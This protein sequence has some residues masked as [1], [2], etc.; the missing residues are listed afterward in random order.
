[1]FRLGFPTLLLLAPGALHSQVAASPVIVQLSAPVGETTHQEIDATIERAMKQF[2]VPG[3]SVAVVKEGK[4]ILSKGYGVRNIAT[5]QPMTSDTIVPIFS[6][7]KQFTSFAAGLMVDEKKLAFNTPVVSYFPQ[8]KTSDPIS[9]A[10]VTLRDLLSHRSGIPELT[11]LERDKSL[12]R[13]QAVERLQ[14]ISGFDSPRNSYSYSNYGYAIASRIIENAAGKRFE[15]FVETRIFAPTGMTRSTY[16]YEVAASSP[17]HLS[18]VV[19]ELGKKVAL[20]LPRQSNLNAAAGGIYSSADDM[21]KWMLLQLST[22]KVGERQLIRPETLAYLRQPAYAF[23]PGNNAPDLVRTGYALG[24]NN[25]VYRGYPMIRHG[26]YTPGV[27]TFLA[28]LPQQGIGV[29]VFTNHDLPP[30]VEGLTNTLLDRTIGEKTRDWLTESLKHQQAIEASI[31]LP[32][33]ATERSR[34]PGTHISHK[35]SDYAGTYHH[36]GYG[37]VIVREEEGRLTIEWATYRTP[38][39]HWHYDVFQTTTTDETS[40]WAPGGSK[41]EIRFTA[42]FRGRV[43][44]LQIG[45]LTGVSG[46]IFEKQR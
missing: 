21:S 16:S 13:Q 2:G 29:A 14:Y 36:P 33:A 19:V 3:V 15:D 17:N 32:P 38:L 30:F 11:F 9:T 27:N 8:F 20:P 5:R 4:V 1:L 23:G 10:S 24:W 31:A 43:S 7:A 35:L 34:V 37:S 22:G 45:G 25:D 28:L 41:A 6:I 40:V 46:V 42:D 12:T 44:A 18:P 39:S 26:G